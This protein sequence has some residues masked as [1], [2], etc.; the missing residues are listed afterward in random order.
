[1]WEQIDTLLER[2]P[3]PALRLHR[4]ELL[5]A[6]RRR[7]AGLPVP[8]ALQAEEAEAVLRELAVRPLLARV[9]ET[10]D[11]PL[12]LM[13]G[14]EVAL[15]YP[16]PGLRR[17]GDL[18]LLAADPE[19]AQAA[20]LAA[21]FREILPADWFHDIHHLRPLWWPGLPLYVELHE[22]PQWP[23]HV[24]APATA[25]LL[26]AAVPSRLG[27]AGVDALPP[28]AHA[29]ALAAHDWAHQPLGRLGN[30]ID[31]A[32]TLRRTT[33]AEADALARR[34]GCGRMW[35]TAR[36][37]AEALL[38]GDGRSSAAMLWARHLAPLRERTVF[39]WH[40]HRLLSP[41]WGRP[42]G[43]AAAGA[44]AAL[45]HDGRPLAGEAS[46]VK[47]RRTALALRQAGVPRSVHDLA[48]DERAGG[49]AR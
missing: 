43:T 30:L 19:R 40:A 7:A 23:A 1:M 2:A 24:P 20:L 48:L 13:K 17:F 44:L 11:G 49:E 14:P 34:W 32:A 45:A 6:R 27:V 33:G 28:A 15:D 41:L 31:V 29:I 25:E 8:P 26:E 16:A 38:E 12:V 39:E 5:D 21:G 47:A 46:G 10:V 4:V 35:R 36:R 18:D 37:A 9:R 3:Q 22:R 42:A